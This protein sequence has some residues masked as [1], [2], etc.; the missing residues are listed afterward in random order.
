MRTVRNKLPYKARE[1]ELRV[2]EPL[3]GGVKF[4]VLSD[5]HPEEVSPLL[6]SK[7]YG[8]HGIFIWKLHLS[9]SRGL[10]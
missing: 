3:D 9:I 10:S 2:T 7:R 1:L 4:Q 8:L 5:F 6:E